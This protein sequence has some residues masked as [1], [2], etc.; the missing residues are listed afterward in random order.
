M[1][2]HLDVD[3]GIGQAGLPD[4]S[5]QIRNRPSKGTRP[6]VWTQDAADQPSDSVT[7]APICQCSGSLGIDWNDDI[8]CLVHG[9]AIALPRRTDEAPAVAVK[10][11][12]ALLAPATVR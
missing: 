8:H 12:S 6:S 1:S 11:A 4:F 2:R 5:L 7:I 3:F 9:G 10:P